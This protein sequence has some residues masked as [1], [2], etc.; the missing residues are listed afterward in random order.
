MINL[1]D[2]VSSYSVEEQ[3]VAQNELKKGISI[4]LSKQALDKLE[5]IRHQKGDIMNRSQIIELL[6][7][8]YKI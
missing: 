3:P 7:K 4:T 1:K 5:F 6:I 8:E 2:R